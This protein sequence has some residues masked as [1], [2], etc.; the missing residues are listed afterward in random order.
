MDAK[1][2]P[3]IEL[4]EHVPADAHMVYEHDQFHSQNIP[5]GRLCHE[6]AA[7]LKEKNDMTRDD[8]IRMAREAGMESNEYM[9][10]EALAHTAWVCA[11][12]DLIRFAALVAASEREAC[13]SVC[14]HR[15]MQFNSESPFA[16]ECH[17]LADAIRAR[18]TT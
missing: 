11:P 13:A 9:L 14:D 10:Y 5:V 1:Q 2:T 6:A 17:N 8:I 16:V 18:G 3:L 7:A 12:G 15:G 4:L